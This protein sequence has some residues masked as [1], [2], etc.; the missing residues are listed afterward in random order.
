VDSGMPAD[1]AI[2]DSEWTPP[3]EKVRRM[4]A[5]LLVTDRPSV[6]LLMSI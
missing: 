6:E 4:A 1:R 3:L 5:S 2:S